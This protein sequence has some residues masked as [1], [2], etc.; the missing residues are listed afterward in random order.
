[1]KIYGLSATARSIS[2]ESSIIPEL[3]QTQMTDSKSFTMIYTHNNTQTKNHTVS[4]GQRQPN[5]KLLKVKRKLVRKSN[6]FA[7]SDFVYRDNS[8]FITKISFAFDVSIY[9]STID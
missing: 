5:D 9:Y 6:H 1:M 8:R 4:L 7:E 2:D 3:F